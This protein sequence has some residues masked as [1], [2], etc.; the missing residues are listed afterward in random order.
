MIQIGPEYCTSI[1]DLAEKI[2]AISG[3]E[4]QILYDTTKPEGDRGLCANTKKARE[5]LGWAA[6]VPLEEGLRELY[7]WMN[8][9][10]SDL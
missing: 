7:T 5:I 1:R 9:T 10:I 6:C 2:V 8:T 4:I 3:K